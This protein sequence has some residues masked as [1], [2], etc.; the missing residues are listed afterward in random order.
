MIIGQ[1]LYLVIGFICLADK[2]NFILY[3]A[4]TISIR[5]AVIKFLDGHVHPK[6]YILMMKINAEALAAI[7]HL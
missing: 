4:A 1:L 2:I 7:L 3:L 6:C 5:T